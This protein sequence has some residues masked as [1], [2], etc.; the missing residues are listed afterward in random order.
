MCFG[1]KIPKYGNSVPDPPKIEHFDFFH[2]HYK[3]LTNTLPMS[4]QPLS[5]DNFKPRNVQNSP[6]MCFGPKIPKYGNLVPDPTKIEHFEF[7][8]VHY[9]RL[10]NTLP[11][12]PRPLSG[13]NFKPRNV[14]NS[15]EM[16]FGPKIPKYGNSV[17]DPPKIENF[18]FFHVQ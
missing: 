12:S 11:T 13:D 6:K 9:K 15:P 1:P 2:V 10:T 5:G 3:R 18:D 14:Q 7:F 8:H 17:P 16:C 4:P